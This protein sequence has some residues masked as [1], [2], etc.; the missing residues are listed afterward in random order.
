M[1]KT[2]T[3]LAL[4]A[5]LALHAATTVNVGTN[6]VVPGVKRFGVSGISHYYYDRVLLKNLVWHNAGFEGLLF[7][8]V[9]RC[10]AAGTPTGCVDDN[11]ST[12]WPSGFWDGGTFEFVLGAAKGRS[13]TIA[14]FVAAP[15]DNVTGSTFNFAASGTAPAAGDY[16][17]ARKYT[18]GGA[19]MGWNVMANGGAAIS[20][21]LADLPPDTAGRQC[22]RISAAGT[23]QFASIN[24]AFGAFGGSN[25]VIMNGTYRVTFKAKG[26]G[27]NN[28]VVVAVARGNNTFTNQNVTLSTSWSTYT[29]D[30][31]A[32]ETSSA[33][34]GFVVLSFT[35]TGSSVLLDDVSLEQTNGDPTNTTAF[36]DPVV[37]ALRS[38][39]PGGLRAHC[40]DLGDSLDDL[41]APPFG[42]RRPEYSVYATNK[43]TI[44]YGWHEFL[45]LCELL[46]AEPYLPIPIVF[47]DAEAA[48]L[49]EYLAGPTTSPYGARR[50]AR[51]HPAPWTDSFT[52]IHLEIGNEAWNPV[53]RGGTLLAADYGHRGNDFFAVMRQ[54]PYYSSKFNLI[55]GIQAANPFNSR[56]THN[57]SSMHD[58]LAIGPYIATR[59]DD[60]ANNEQ[61]FGSLFAEASWWSS[62]AVGT[63]QAGPVRQ[64]YDMVSASTRP[65]P[66]MVYEVNLHTTQGSI[67][68]PV[69]D[70]FTPSLG[71][72][73][74]VADHM[75]IMLRDEKIR[76]QYIF[77]LGGYQYTR[78]DQKTVLLWS[79]TRDM[80]I[81]DRKR[82]QY[83]AVKLINEV[84][85]GDM[86]QTTQWGD[87]P[88][89]NE[90]LTNR[91]QLDNVP[92]IQSFAFVNGNRRA[93]VLFN[94]SRTSSLD[95]NFAGANAPSGS[96]TIKHLTSANLTDTNESAEN[97][98]VTTDT[99]SSFDPAATMT[100]PP[101]SMTVISAGGQQQAAARL[102]GDVSGNGAVTAFDA[103]LVLQDVVGATTLDA[104]SLCAADYN[105]NGA[106]TAFDA[107]LILQCVVGGACSSASCN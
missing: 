43:G 85:G 28:R 46:G 99:A 105:A 38:F 71:A 45:E 25:F 10:G 5:S 9:I 19:D 35:P 63:P 58:T 4:S 87:N 48:N 81:N 1:R 42:H 90:P 47:S 36:R 72:G 11:P 76:D 37:A 40:L 57:A 74:A 23:G 54:S 7:Q 56:V 69:L 96:V 60:F 50:A 62:P 29:V 103:S 27:G 102:R 93:L 44:P 31:S 101:Y 82:P 67:T 22:I 2:I 65:V 84:L 55:L 77:S 75:L 39:N 33:P 24:T 83:L 6:V 100:L 91:I 97:I 94:L 66:L 51:G 8:S 92:F 73:L 98:V 26:V 15:H 59:I 21:E 18:P 104:K 53:F 88:T 52:R 13:G 17:I 3:L 89:W 32:A 16:F 30:F 70:T 79:I 78:D 61:L 41:I 14:S 107:S 34:V 86:V 12:Q 68:Q 20:T 95:V 64:I 80:G 106:V 49:I